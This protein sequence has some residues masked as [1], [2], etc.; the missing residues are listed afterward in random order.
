MNRMEKLVTAYNKTSYKIHVLNIFPEL[1]TNPHKSLKKL[2]KKLHNLSQTI[3]DRSGLDPKETSK[4]L[5]ELHRIIRNQ[6][7]LATGEDE[8][9]GEILIGHMTRKLV[10]S[11]NMKPQYEWSWTFGYA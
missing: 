8:F 2:N 9:K 5:K 7:F 6:K 10:D 1:V 3:Q 11:V 4:Q